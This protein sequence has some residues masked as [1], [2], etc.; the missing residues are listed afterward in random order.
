MILKGLNLTNSGFILY[1][2]IL[3]KLF[4]FQFTY[5]SDSYS[6]INIDINHKFKI[7]TLDGENSIKR[8][9]FQISNY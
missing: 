8:R 1:I 9:S 4:E 2:R 6:L 3:S 7:S 5:S